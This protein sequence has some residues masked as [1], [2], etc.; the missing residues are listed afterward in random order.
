MTEADKV[1]MFSGTFCIYKCSDCATILP[2]SKS[3][4]MELGVRP[5]KTQNHEAWT[6]II[7]FGGKEWI[8]FQCED[9]FNGEKILSVI[10]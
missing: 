8:K 3:S 10:Y 7:S 4:N 9:K 6:K 5:Y 2:W 1:N